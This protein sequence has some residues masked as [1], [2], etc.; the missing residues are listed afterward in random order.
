MIEVELDIFSGHRNP[1]WVL[2]DD[3]VA[4][5]RSLVR[6]ERDNLLP[7]AQAPEGLG[8]KGYVVRAEGKDARWFSD[9]GLP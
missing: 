6:N 8:F 7:L 1:R 4:D 9:R 5:F 2:A 3:E